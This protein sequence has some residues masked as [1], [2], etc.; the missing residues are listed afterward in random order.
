MARYLAGRKT[1]GAS[2]DLAAKFLRPPGND[3]APAHAH[4]A[5]DFT[6]SRLAAPLPDIRQSL[7]RLIYLLEPLLGSRFL[8]AVRMILEGQLAER[9]PDLLVG[10]V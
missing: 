8:V 10:G 6:L 3:L 4:V 2:Q 5:S 9:S 7:V 1:L